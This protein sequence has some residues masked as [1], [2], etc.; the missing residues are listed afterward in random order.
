MC[1]SIGPPSPS[2]IITVRAP[3]TH[4]RRDVRWTSPCG[5]HP[6]EGFSNRMFQGWRTL[7]E[8]HAT[9]IPPNVHPLCPISV[10]SSPILC[11]P[12]FIPE[13]LCFIATCL[14]ITTFRTGSVSVMERKRLDL[15]APFSI[16]P[17]SLYFKV[18][19]SYS[20]A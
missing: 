15:Y 18:R 19:V 2:S 8:I 4:I 10:L 17:V 12:D 11:P 3:A 9:L 1:A 14:S 13:H 5:I 20:G 16:K 7:I 6:Y